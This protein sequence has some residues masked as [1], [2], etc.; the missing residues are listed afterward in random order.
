MNLRWIFNTSL[1]HR[2]QQH[3][4]TAQWKLWNHIICLDTTVWCCPPI[5]TFSSYPGLWEVG[6]FS[7]RSENYSHYNR[8]G[9]CTTLADNTHHGASGRLGTRS[10]RGVNHTL[11]DHIMMWSPCVQVTHRLLEQ[12][13]PGSQASSSSSAEQL[14]PTGP[15]LG[16]RQEQSGRLVQDRR[17][18]GAG[19]VGQQLRLQDWPLPERSLGWH[20]AGG[21]LT[22]ET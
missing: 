19:E 8:C 3:G 22:R 1:Q 6:P 13:F 21:A 16:V 18:R 5:S 14:R 7:K 11:I 15:S 17:A 2:C 9:T 4:P 10:Q 20:C 12:V